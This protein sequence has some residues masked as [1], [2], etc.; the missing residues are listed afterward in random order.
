MPFLGEIKSILPKDE[1][2]TPGLIY[3]LVAGLS[4]SVLTRTRA[5]PIRWLTP[6]LF[7]L[8]AMPYFL[9]KTAHNLRN[10]LSEVEDKHFPEF[11]MRHDQFNSNA[12]TH[13]A[14]LFNRVGNWSKEAN[15]LGDKAMRGIEDSTGLKVGDLVRKAERERARVEEKVQIG[16]EPV[17]VKTVGYVVESRPVAEIVAPVTEAEQTGA[18]AGSKPVAPGK[19]MV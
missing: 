2:L 11:A 8:I 9:P 13:T 17:P 14:Q 12:E 19:R 16:S 15:K 5:F 3:V 4:G 10:Y 7:T 6:P 1:S 18:A